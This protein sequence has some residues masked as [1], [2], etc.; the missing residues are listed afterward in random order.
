M[1]FGTAV[2]VAHA[3]KSS[4]SEQCKRTHLFSLKG[5]AGTEGRVWIIIQLLLVGVHN[6][7]SA[8]FLVS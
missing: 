8:V 4:V 5:D 1:G 3:V 7:D 6:T 2:L